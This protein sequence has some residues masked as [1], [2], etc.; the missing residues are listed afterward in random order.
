MPPILG[1][2]LLREQSNV[3]DNIGTSDWLYAGGVAVKDVVYVSGADT[4]NKGDANG[5]PNKPC[6]GIVTAIDYPIA[7]RCVVR[8]LGEVTGFVG[9]VPG[10]IYIVSTTPGVLV[11]GADGLNPAYPTSGDFKQTIGVAKTVTSLFAM[12]DPTPHLIA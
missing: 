4:V 11:G 9:L 12:V 2:L 3:E 5:D 8:T 10:T 6:I 7:G 1:D